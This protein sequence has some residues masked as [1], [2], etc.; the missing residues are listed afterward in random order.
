[1]AARAL[2][3][4]GL[5]LALAQAAAAAD[6]DLALR[7]GL[8][9]LGGDGLVGPGD[10]AV[11]GDRIAAVGE[12]PGTATREIDASGLVIAPGFID[13]HN[14]SDVVYQRL[15]WLPLPES[16]HANLNYLTQGVTTIVTGNCGSGFAAPDEVAG[17]LERVDAMPFGSNVVHL[18]PH[19]ELRRLVMGE[20]QA[21]REDP[22]P[23]PAELRRM[24]EMLYASLR[25]GA[26]GLSTGL[27]YEP[28]GR[29]DTA[30]IVELALVAA[31]RGGVYASHTRHEGPDPERMLASY[32]E[33]IEIGERAGLPA[34]ISHIKLSGRGVHGMAAQVIELVESARRRGVAVTADQYPYTAGSTTLARPVPLEMRDGE[35]ADARFCA[36]PARTQMRAGVER[37]LREEIPADRMRI[38]FYPWR[39]WWQGRTLADVAR[40]RGQDPA[41][42]AIELACG[43]PGLG[44]YFSQDEADLRALMARDWVATAS[45]GTAIA[46]F[47]ARFSHPRWFGTF[48]RKLAHYARDEAVVS[49]PFALRS[50]TALPAESF[51]I[52]ERGRLR[53]GWYADVVAFDAEGLRDRATFEQP[54]LPSEGVVYLLVNGVLSIDA[55]RYTGERG[56]RALRSQGRLRQRVA[57]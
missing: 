2:G 24:K 52:P 5:L 16:L 56:G 51:G 36:G 40:G 45:D 53:P 55:G 43:W 47:P 46:G 34:H 28:G 14:H 12:A 35:S 33:A 48:P 31:E 11:R 54:G 42:L 17:W 38:A 22:R 1:M 3:A 30:E 4:I 37:F 9:Y 13:L 20:G 41:D 27:E 25:A 29:A 15:G 26:W 50:M 7:G 18:V 8:L 23:T 10:L 57:P 49:L 39:W 44:I 32:A 6:Y 21:S 19:G